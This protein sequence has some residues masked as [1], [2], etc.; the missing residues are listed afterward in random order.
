MP[1]RCASFEID[2]LVTD[3]GAADEQA[4]LFTQAGVTVARA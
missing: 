4:R 3:T 1:H 2:A